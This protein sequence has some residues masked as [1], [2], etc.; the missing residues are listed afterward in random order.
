MREMS[1]KAILRYRMLPA[2]E[3]GD[4]T[5]IYVYG[6]TQLSYRMSS[7]HVYAVEDLRLYIAVQQY[8]EIDSKV[9]VVVPYAQWRIRWPVTGYIGKSCKEPCWFQLKV[10]NTREA[11]TILRSGADVACGF[12]VRFA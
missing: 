7:F 1:R 9:G 3:G 5:H 10:S 4:Y 2:D 8:F 11:G 6:T 12:G